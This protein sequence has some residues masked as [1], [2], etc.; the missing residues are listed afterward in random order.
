MFSAATRLARRQV[1]AAAPKRLA[2]AVAARPAAV[3]RRFLST[4]AADLSKAVNAGSSAESFKEMGLVTSIGDGVAK[5]VGLSNIQAGEQVRFES[6]VSG[7]ALNLE[8]DLV[9]IALFGNDNQVSEGDRA[10]RTH[11]II[12]I[13]TGP[14]ML[15]RVVDSLGNTIDG[16]TPLEN[17][18]ADL[19]EL[20]VKA[21]GIIDR[22]SVKQ[23]LQV[24]HNTHTASAAQK[25]NKKAIPCVLVHRLN[26]CFRFFFR[27]IFC[28]VVFLD[29][30]HGRGLHD[31]HR[32]G[33][34]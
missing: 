17:T 14:Q 33:S 27:I 8:K 34:A 26:L 5:V 19:Q 18:A 4:A 3:Q 21:P 28:V 32:Q 13:P 7:I 16:D 22:E 30:N 1:L 31:S 12:S 29:W 20:D 25:R 2:S 10:F 11:S 6:G 15:G 9:G 24:T 23:P